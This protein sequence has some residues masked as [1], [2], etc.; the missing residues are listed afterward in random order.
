MAG[1]TEEQILDAL[2]DVIVQDEGTDVVS[3]GMVSGVVIRN[4]N[5]GFA[6][7]IDPERA[8][9]MEIVRKDAEKAVQEIDGVLSVTAVLTAEREAPPQQ[10]QQ[11]QPPRQSPGQSTPG[12]HPGGHAGGQAQPPAKLL[13]QVSAVI[14]VAS[15]KGGVGKSTTSVNLALAFAQ[16]G[17][18][19]GILDADIYGPSL[20]MLLGI[21]DKP[22]SPDGKTLLPIERFGLK[23]HVDRIHGGS[24]F[25][26]DL[27]RPD[28]NGR[29]GTD[30]ARRTV[31]QSRR[32]GG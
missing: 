19:T 32:A 6:L 11:A 14:A 18:V 21:T 26:D 29:S 25:A 30:D 12:A 28:G 31:G 9:V 2:G 13:E 23:V 10:T 8:D 20:P 7:E 15:G 16:R 27:A 3:L 1:P 22:Q 24:G 5:V 4:G 17:L